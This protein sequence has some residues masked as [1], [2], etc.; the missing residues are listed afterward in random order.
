VSGDEDRRGLLAESLDLGRDLGPRTLSAELSELTLSREE[1]RLELAQVLIHGI[2]VVPLPDDRE[3]RQDRIGM[4]GPI[5]VEEIVGVT[6][7]ELP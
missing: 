7:Q 2:A 3:G 6:V 1:L 5:D 4:R